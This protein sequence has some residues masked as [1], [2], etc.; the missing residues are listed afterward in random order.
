[1]SNHINVY[2]RCG[3]DEASICRFNAL[4]EDVFDHLPKYKQ[5]FPDWEIWP[6][7]IMLGTELRSEYQKH[8]R[9]K[10]GELYFEY[11]TYGE[12]SRY[13]DLAEYLSRLAPDTD[14]HLYAGED[15]YMP[16]SGGHWVF[17]NGVQQDGGWAENDREGMA[18][19]EQ[20]RGE[21]PRCSTCAL[22]DACQPGSLWPTWETVLNMCDPDYD[23]DND[24]YRKE[25]GPA[26]DEGVA[27][28]EE[29]RH[30]EVDS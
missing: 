12:V 18:I 27:N 24:P 11:L 28:N 22:F 9:P 15:C 21:E 26:D 14:I 1:M 19:L 29:A 20:I 5:K 4:I 3:T 13:G 6:R 8:Y 16:Y 10:R 2:I 30:E 25:Y 23:P 17:R 7:T